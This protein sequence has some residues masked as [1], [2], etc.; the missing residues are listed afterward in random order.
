MEMVIRVEALYIHPLRAFMCA[1]GVYGMVCAA[2]C[3]R[4]VCTAWYVQHGVYISS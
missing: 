2:W 4:V 3:V 1:R